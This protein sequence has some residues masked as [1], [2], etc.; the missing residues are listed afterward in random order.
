MYLLCVVSMIRRKG[1]EQVEFNNDV[2]GMA[3]FVVEGEEYSEDGESA[4]VPA[5][6][7]KR[8]DINS[9]PYNFDIEIC[10]SQSDEAVVIKIPA[11]FKRVGEKEFHVWYEDLITRKYWDGV[12]KVI[13]GN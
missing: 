12:V 6:V 8:V 10:E 3:S 4:I 13:H 7:L 9:I 5:A 11:Y 2:A 1:M